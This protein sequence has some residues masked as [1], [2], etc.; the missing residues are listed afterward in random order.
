[1]KKFLVVAFVLAAVCISTA[2]YAIDV[3]VNGEADVR[4]RLFMNIDDGAT[5]NSHTQS[6]NAAYTQTR[7]D[8]SINIKGEGFRGRLHVWNDHD[9]WGGS[10]TGGA[11]A[12]GTAGTQGNGRSAVDNG[13]NNRGTQGT[14]STVLIREAFVEFTVPGTPVTLLAGRYLSQLGNGWF[15]RSMYGGQEGWL[16]TVPIGKVAE[17]AFE[18]VKVSEGS[19][20]KQRDDIDLYIFKAAVKPSDKFTIGTNVSYLK[21]NIGRILAL[22][23]AQGGG[24]LWN[25]G[26]YWNGSLGIVR[27]KGQIDVQSGYVQTT[28]ATRSIDYDGFQGI[29]QIEVPV[30]IVTLRAGAAYGS[31]NRPGSSNN[32]G[33]IVMLDSPRHY[34]YIYEYRAKGAGQI[35]GG[36]QSGLNNT[37]FITGG[38]QVEAGKSL[39]V[40]FD[41]YLLQAAEWA[42]TT[43]GYNGRNTSKDMGVE[44]DFNLTWK[45]APNVQWTWVAAWL[46]TGNGYRTAGGWTSDM[47]AIEGVLS[48]KF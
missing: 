24:N 13:N 46:A 6:G 17:V 36:K 12:T 21:D 39:S 41:T 7:Y 16:L 40:G 3:T 4:S 26:L 9:D 15:L 23:A 1:M 25:L 8:V 37:M 5:A 44:T 27:L 38:V 30:S 20:T 19:E 35:Y 32:S 48:L 43:A 45:I 11:S 28:A 47:Y 34:T 14:V 18:N 2:A 42:P 33:V 22:P 10:N 31:G 29:L